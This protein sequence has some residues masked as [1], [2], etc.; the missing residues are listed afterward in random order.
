M[1]MLEKD[2]YSAH[3]DSGGVQK[4]AHF[5]KV[6]CVTL[7]NETEW[8]ELVELGCNQIVPPTDV[9]SVVEALR[10]ALQSDANFA[11]Q[12]YG[13]SHTAERIFQI[14]LEQ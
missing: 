13:D 3:D 14:L 1:I 12:P 5:D 8:V 2:A 4:E 10:S 11:A 9:E 6:P 7:R